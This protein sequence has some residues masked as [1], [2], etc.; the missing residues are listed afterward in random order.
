MLINACV[1]VAHKSLGAT[2]ST[3]PLELAPLT[4]AMPLAV[5]ARSVLNL[6]TWQA[7]AQENR[8]VRH[9][10]RRAWFPTWCTMLGNNVF[11]CARDTREGVR[12]PRSSPLARDNIVGP[13]AKT[14]PKF[15]YLPSESK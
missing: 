15:P 5:H 11:A 3:L 1:A 12:P 4:A 8:F 7:E 14:G 13:A 2:D 9:Y 10:I 6:I